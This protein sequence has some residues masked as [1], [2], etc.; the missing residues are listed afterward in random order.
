[1]ID[2]GTG[3]DILIGGDG[4]EDEIYYTK[5]DLLVEGGEGPDKFWRPSNYLFFSG[6]VLLP[7]PNPDDFQ[8]GVDNISVD[9]FMNLRFW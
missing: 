6:F 1:M 2:G 8:R 9:Y 7:Y 4:V 5:E 3:R